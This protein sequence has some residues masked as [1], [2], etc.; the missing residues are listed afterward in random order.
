MIGSTVSHYK[1]LDRLGSGGMAVVY[2]CE[3]Q[4]L[5]RQ[6]ALKFLPDAVAKDA[7][8]LARFRRE[9]RAASALNHP[10]ICTIHELGE[11][12]GRPFI[13][14]E[15][16]EGRTLAERIGGR[17]LAAERVLQIGAQVADALEAAHGA[18]IV[19]R[20]LKSA[21]LFVTAR[22][23]A[24]VL[25]FGLAQVVED[26][27]GMASSAPAA[28]EAV[29]E[30]APGQ[31]TT[32]GSTIGTI[33]Y[34]SPEQVRGEPLDERTDLFSL[35]VVLYEMATGRQPF[36]GRTAGAVFDAILNQQPTAA[37][38]LAPELPRGLE[39]II[40]KALEKD[41]ALRYQSAAEMRADL[42]RLERD[43]S[44]APAAGPPAGKPVRARKRWLPLAVA[45]AAAAAAI[46]GWRFWPPT[47]AAAPAAGAAALAATAALPSIAVLPFQNLGQ[48]ASIDYLRLAVPDEITTTLSRVTALAV[49]PFTAAASYA[50]S[51][52]DLEA[53]GRE[54]RAGNLLTGQYY[55][56]DTDLTL[57]LEA[58]SVAGNRLIWRSRV[59]A[60]RDDLLGLRARVAG[61]IRDGLLPALGVTPESEVEDQP[62]DPRAY[63][64][65]IRSLAAPT[66]KEPNLQAIELLEQAVALEPRFARAWSELSY[67]LYYDGLYAQ[68]GAAALRESITAAERA[69]ELDPRLL[70]P[71]LQLNSR[72]VDSGDLEGAYREAQ[73]LVAN[74]PDS[75][76]SWFARSYVYRYAG[77]L[78]E[79]AR[80]CLQ[81]FA[82]DPFN[83]LLR[84]CSILFALRQEWERAYQFL[85]LE[86]GSEYFH[87]VHGHFL[88][89]RG[90]VEGA[91][92][93]LRRQSADTV[94]Q[95]EADVLDHCG[96][97]TP[98]AASVVA[99]AVRELSAINDSEPMYWAG[100]LLA[101]CGFADE[102]LHMLR[103]AIDRGYCSYPALDTD[104]QWA[105]LRQDPEFLELRRGAVAC[106][107]RFRDFV[108]SGQ[109]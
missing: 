58:V 93:S 46:A 20:D 95:V 44:A 75:P 60:P 24:K 15:L 103:L 81:A 70:E 101:L 102:A 83:R 41:R 57:T 18:G 67:R 10:H 79:G 14:M 62:T 16:M 66:S 84:S 56:E 71:Q 77:L 8:A 90:D 104:L 76:V 55:A 29:T 89:A 23:D 108:Q 36:T 3:D 63:E 2:R 74:R 5:G 96:Q 86:R 19:H 6:V 21:N 51:P 47:P 37:T 69:I 53:A 65:Y 11:E 78:E 35:G 22:G 30:L 91:R 28:A 26:Q 107:D 27:A 92:Q 42:L 38:R 1:I 34:M 13:V 45:A 48:D 39:R 54:L 72:R 105:A 98:E 4:V 106:R 43:A 99:R 49:R 87:D 31:L 50:E 33:A 88:A 61:L 100:G 40:D 82:L 109:G 64:L 12:A 7:E 85:D 94:W 73:R 25:D 9:A 97:S 32:P 59:S 68:G 52:T 17:P 80:D